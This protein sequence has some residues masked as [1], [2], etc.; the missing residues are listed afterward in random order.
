M[1]L[2]PGDICRCPICSTACIVQYIDEE[3]VLIISDYLQ[4]VYNGGKCSKGSDEFLIKLSIEEL[5]EL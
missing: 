1:K 2:K 5:L 4:R 3:Q